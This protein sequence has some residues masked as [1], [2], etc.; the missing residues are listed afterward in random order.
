MW[1]D[2]SVSRKQTVEL[3]SLEEDE[4]WNSASRRKYHTISGA[5]VSRINKDDEEIYTYDLEIDEEDAGF[6]PATEGLFRVRFRAIA[7]VELAR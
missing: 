4:F 1:L 7:M 6:I 2:E 5:R 3:E